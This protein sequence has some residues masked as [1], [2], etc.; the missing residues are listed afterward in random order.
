LKVVMV[1]PFSVYP[2]GTVTVRMLPIAK[3]LKKR[4]HDVTVVV[5]PYDNPTESGKKYTLEDV[6]I[7]NVTFRDF[8]LIKYP[9]VLLALCQTILSL[10]PNCIY[11]F[12]PK[13]YSGLAAIFFVLFRSLIFSKYPRLLLDTD[14]WEGRGGFYDFFLEKSN[15]SRTILDFIDFQEN[16]IPLH[17]DAVTVASRT[18]QNRLIKQGIPEKKIFYVPNGAPTKDF[19]VDSNIVG[20]LRR[21]LILSNFSVIIL[22][23]RFLE[24]DVEK[25]IEIFLQIKKEIQNAKLLVI[26][27]GDFG[28]ERILQKLATEKNVEDSIVFAGWI[29]ARDIPLYLA[30]GEVAIYPLDDTPLNRSKCPGKLVELML[31]GKAIVADKVG[32]VSEYIIDGESGILADH[33]N[34]ANFALETITLLRNE[35]LASK[36]GASAKI[37]ASETFNWEKLAENVQKAISFSD[38]R[39]KTER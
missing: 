22:Y 38:S 2:K 26:G 34:V 24:Y 11:V 8:P 18:L 37:R 39:R 20:S 7:H 6:E 13:G 35:K 12:K 14:D 33:N 5:P 25:V 3:F 27:K 31:A 30:L 28:E 4:G 36:L 10:R 29:Q 16:W 15:Y 1:A 17:M 23:T 9:L 19:S 32:Q 21:S